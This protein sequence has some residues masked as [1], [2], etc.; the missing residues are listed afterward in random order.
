MPRKVRTLEER[1][2]DLEIRVA[3]Q[4]AV[5]EEV[6]ALLSAESVR[7]LHDQGYNTRAIA[8]MMGRPY[9]YVRGVLRA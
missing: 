3:D 1:I 9:S 2:S 4:D 6:Y 5:I 8:E 7:R